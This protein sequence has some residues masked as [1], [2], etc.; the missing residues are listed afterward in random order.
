MHSTEFQF[1]VHHCRFAAMLLI[2]GAL[3]LLLICTD[4]LSTVSPVSASQKSQ[5]NVDPD[6]TRIDCTPQMADLRIS[7]VKNEGG[8][9]LGHLRRCGD[10]LQRCLEASPIAQMLA[11]V[12]VIGFDDGL[13]DATFSSR[14]AVLRLMRIALSLPNFSVASYVHSF[15]FC[16]L[17]I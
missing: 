16:C 17:V 5:E 8:S 12:I 11:V 10:A 14:S 1:F 13:E 4:F 15:I 2:V 9:V 7:D 6:E 3:D